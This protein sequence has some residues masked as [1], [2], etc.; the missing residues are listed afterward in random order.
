MW[1]RDVGAAGN[2][3][4]LEIWNELLRQVWLGY[5]NDSNSSGANPT[6]ESYVGYLCET[7][8]QLL[9]LRRQNHG[10]L[11]PEEFACGHMLSWLHLTVEYDTPLVKD[12]AAT[13]GDFGNPAD[14]LAA[15]GAR[16][17]IAPSRQARELFELADKF[18][19]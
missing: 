16:V 5:E 4:F 11:A 19:P 15:I 7:L 13:T 2:T 1:K 8:S 9:Q 3:R 17:G 6:D 14:R 18:L 10:M 12:L